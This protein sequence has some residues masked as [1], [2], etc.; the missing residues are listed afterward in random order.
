MLLNDL[1]T[2][3]ELEESSGSVLRFKIEIKANHSVFEGH[4]PGNPVMPGVCQM[5]IVKEVVR[6]HF[7]RELFFNSVADMKF[8]NMWLPNETKLVF[9][10]VLAD[11]T[12]IGFKIKASI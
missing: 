8:I 2:Y 4:F 7:K 1:F 3:S 11:K 9:L 12:E 5:E 6:S 10:D